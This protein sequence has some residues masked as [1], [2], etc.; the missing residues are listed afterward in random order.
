MGYRK[1]MET[2]NQIVLCTCPS[3]EVA[4]G[5][6]GALVEQALAACVNIIPGI[7]SVYHW[8]G[9]V[10]TDPEWLLVIK[11]PARAYPK[12]EAAITSLHPYELPE[13]I[14]VPIVAG[15]PAY[16]AWMNERGGDSSSTP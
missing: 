11:A 10:E 7:E 9:R 8:Q 6:A 13:I 14:A 1:D 12:L 5:L 3:E 15:L 16:L 2:G 4:R